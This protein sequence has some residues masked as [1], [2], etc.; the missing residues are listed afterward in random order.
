[1]T[2]P[3]AVFRVLALAGYFA[4]LTLLLNWHT[5]IAPPTRVPIS[6]VLLLVAVPLLLP[7]R[8][9][10]HGRV[11]THAWTSFL[12][13]AY[14]ALAVDAIAADVQPAWLGWAALVASLALFTGAIGYTRT[15]GRELRSAAGE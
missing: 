9:L 15:R 8:G 4:L 11:Y 2:R 6:V 10:L 1:M 13:L 14:F 3:V 7:L 12:A 5:W